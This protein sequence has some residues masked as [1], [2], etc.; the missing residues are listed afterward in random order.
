MFLSNT[1]LSARPGLLL[2]SNEWQ[3]FSHTSKSSEVEGKKKW[4]SKWY[5]TRFVSPSKSPIPVFHTP[6]RKPPCSSTIEQSISYYIKETGLWWRTVNAVKWKCILNLN[7][8]F[9]RLSYLVLTLGNETERDYG[10]A[11]LGFQCPNGTPPS[12]KP[13]LNPNNWIQENPVTDHHWLLLRRP[14]ETKRDHFPH[15]SS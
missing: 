8:L 9:L 15:F 2:R 4:L 7:Y 6:C 5:A 10:A 1:R 11:L 12:H 14:Q 3:H 13:L